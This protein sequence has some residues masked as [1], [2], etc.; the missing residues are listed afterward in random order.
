MENT[1]KQSKKENNMN[2]ITSDLH[3]NHTN[4]A[5]G[6]VSNWPSGFRTFRTVKEMNTTLIDNLNKYVQWDDTLWF[7]GDFCFGGHELTPEWR[8]KINC[9]TIH[10]IRGNHDT[11]AFKYKDHFTSIRDYW[12]GDIEGHQFV[13][14][15]YAMRVWYHNNRGVFHCYGHSHDNLE[16]EEWGKSMDVGVDAAY[17]I[18]GEYRPFSIKEVVDILSK[19]PIKAIDHHTP[20]N[21]R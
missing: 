11:S 17:R 20:K 19:R 3:L 2:W 10:W 12:Q 8:K 15:H 4:I 18:T 14:F 13:L 1:L 9:Q 6:L 16:K 21:I 5:G 7:L